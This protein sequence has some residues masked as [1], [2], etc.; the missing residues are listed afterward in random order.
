MPMASVLEAA[1]A[2]W[3]IVSALAVAGLGVASLAGG[4]SRPPGALAFG[5]FALLWGAHVLA[6][7]AMSLAPEADAARW[8]LL[9]LAFLL[10]LP[11]FLVELS[12]AYAQRGGADLRW[13]A[14]RVAGAAAP[15]LAVVLLVARPEAIYAGPMAFEGGTFPRWGPLFP[16][17]AIAPFF[18]ALA[19]AVWTFEAAR[20]EAPTARTSLRY[21]LLAAGLATFTAFSAG[22]NLAFYLADVLL[23][24]VHPL[25]QPYLVLFALLASL[26]AAVAARALLDARRQAS[27]QVRRGALLVALCVAGPL[28]WGAL[29]GALAYAV[30]PRFQTVGLWRL[31]G[32]AMLAYALA[33]WRIP[34]L[35]DRARRGAAVVAAVAAS[36]VAG[37]LAAGL[38]LLVL[39]G[40]AAPLVA[41]LAV[42]AASLAPTLRLAHR[43]L[44]TD[45][46]EA[47]PEAQ[48]AQRVETYRAA[49]EASMGRGTLAQDEAFLAGLRE[50]LRLSDDAHDVLA[51]VA[52]NAVLPPPGETTGGYERLRLLGEGSEGR[53]WLA[54]RRADDAL[55]V[56]KEP[57]ASDPRTGAA[58]RRQA[59]LLRGLRHPNLVRLHETLPHPG[60]PVLVMEYA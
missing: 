28:A 36:L 39:P 50:R 5:A 51:C 12:A 46:A 55:V 24:G 1:T 60:G 8:H 25:A 4:R 37:G 20:Q 57:L 41:A 54:R 3:A 9:Y 6:G 13:R 42:P 40:T 31:V 44:R 15:L 10:P 34:D 11:Y 21:A 48:L 2:T 16:V 26:L 56:L 27:P 53:A 23:A 49:L 58:L 47:G 59:D 14:L 7:Q 17:L 35:A 22:N 52:R 33:R 45:E 30:L 18:L 38:F 43:A 29:E 32:V 19:L